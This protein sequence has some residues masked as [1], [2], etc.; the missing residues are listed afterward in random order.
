MRTE[1]ECQYCAHRLDERPDDFCDSWGRALEE[2]NPER[3]KCYLFR[4]RPIAIIPVNDKRVE[5]LNIQ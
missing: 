4:K 1:N 5:S 3:Y 2:F